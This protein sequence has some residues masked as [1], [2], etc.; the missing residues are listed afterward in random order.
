MLAI[1]WGTA[2]A[3]RENLPVVFQALDHAFGRERYRAC[4]RVHALKLQ[5]RAFREVLADAADQIHRV[6]CTGA[7]RVIS[8]FAKCI[9]YPL[10]ARRIAF[11]Q[12]S[13]EAARW[14]AVRTRKV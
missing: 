1:G 8:L 9:A 6:D 12:Q 3:A 14:K 4:E 2:V 13:I 11:H 5:M 7:L 10:D